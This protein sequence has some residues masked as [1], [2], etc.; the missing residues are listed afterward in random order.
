MKSKIDSIYIKHEENRVY[1]GD[2]LRDFEYPEWVIVE[3][4]KIKINKRKIPYLIVLTQDCDLERDY[5]DRHENN[6]HDKFIHSVLVCPAY[7]SEKLK[8]GTHLNELKLKME[9]FDEKRWHWIKINQNLRYHF[10]EKN[11]ILQIPDL[12]IDFKHYYT[13]PREILY[14]VLKEHYIGTINELFREALSQRF[15]YYLSRIG[16]PKISQDIEH[17]TETT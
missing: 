15:A 12:V 17:K 10:L 1:Q 16:L 13:I 3:N 2:I 4:K 5:E 6:N 14:R 11:E 8:E 7:H 9:K